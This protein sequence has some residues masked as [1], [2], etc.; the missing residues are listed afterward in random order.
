MKEITKDIVRSLS[1]IFEGHPWY[2]DS[3]MRKLENV[4]Y[5]IG[6]K[7]CIPESHSVAQIV[8]HLIAWKSFAVQKL[9]SNNGDSVEIDSEEDWPEI[10]VKSSE[11]WEKLKRKLVAVQGQIYK[12][13][14]EKE[15][16]DFL[17]E[18]VNGKD[19]DFE[20]LLKGIIQHDIYHIGQIG[21]IESQL[22]NKEIDSG[23]FTT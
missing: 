16:D 7:T 22:K 14:Q 10:E 17:K 12:L 2:G 8:G 23:V 4:P 20:C 9:E 15:N 13:L 19:Y 6:Y 5:I 3:V 21:L 1:E 18:R 11:E